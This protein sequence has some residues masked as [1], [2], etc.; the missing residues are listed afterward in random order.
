M[1]CDKDF[2][3]STNRTAYA[4]L[5]MYRYL[6]TYTYTYRERGKKRKKGNAGKWYVGRKHMGVLSSIIS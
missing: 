2:N 6:S 1:K 3:F 5:S 4:C